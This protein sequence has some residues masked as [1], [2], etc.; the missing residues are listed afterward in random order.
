MWEPQWKNHRMNQVLKY[1]GS[2]KAGGVRRN[3][4]GEKMIIEWRTLT[5]CVEAC[6]KQRD[7]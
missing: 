7:I 3:C 1:Q 6:S 4:G 2:V 5:G